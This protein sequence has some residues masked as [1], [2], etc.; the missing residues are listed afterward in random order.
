[1]HRKRFFGLRS[2]ILMFSLIITLLPLLLV[3]TFS[4]RES[5]QMVRSQV[6]DLNLVNAEQI[7]NNL[8]F[9]MNDVETI[10]LNLIQNNVLNDYLLLSNTENRH[11]REPE[12]LSLLNDQLFNKRY[13]YSIYIEDAYG[14]GLDVRGAGNTVDGER[15]LQLQQLRGKEMWYFNSIAIGARQVNAISMVREIRDVNNLSRPL[16]FMKIN[17][18]ES[19]IRDLYRTQVQ[20]KGQFYLLDRDGT[21]LS[22]ISGKEAGTRLDTA[23][24]Y[25]NMAGA[26]AGHFNTTI[27]GERYLA[28][29][30]RMQPIG[31]QIVQLIP[32]DY[33]SQSGDVIGRVTAI[34]IAASL[35]ICIGFILLFAARVLKPLK[36]IRILMKQVEN[37]NF[38][39]RM[40]E[41]GNDEM[42]LLARSFNRMSNKLDELV[43]EVH[44]SKIKQ[45]EAELKAL[46]EQINPHFLYNTL[47]LIYW[48]SR[49]EKAFETSVMIN[50][51]SQLFRI[52]LNS[53]SG[54]TTV[55][56]EV[57]HLHY[58]MLIQQ[59]RY[60][61]EILFTI[62]MEEEAMDCKVTKIILQPL[63][64]NAIS[65]GIEQKGGSGSIRIRI[66]R[67]GGDLVYT[68]TDNG[69]GADEA[70]VNA[71]LHQ[72]GED[73][74]GLALKN[75]NDRIQL[76]FGGSYGIDFHSV[77]MEGTTVTVRQ[78][79]L[80]GTNAH[81]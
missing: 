51:L 26:A 18:L 72:T 58:Y 42:T 49:M 14:N 1:M 12:I 41:R 69:A 25:P 53:G 75:I 23:S 67:E 60:E 81:V 52:G 44:V 19:D 77:P 16:G 57:D 34:T 27:E 36:Q 55:S 13:I 21:I 24:H 22:T 74:R 46:E 59:K 33:I 2:K 37:E 68:V 40:E 76:N 8:T 80:K 6:I 31:W 5:I 45:K 71:L 65:H 64:E 73:N 3:S 38:N 29:F 30:D 63:V 61:E 20:D 47:D 4:Y 50:A 28:I 48:M 10:S 79:W 9:I 78:P 35:V 15:T 62:D 70:A 11:Q 32:Y 43:N 66:F 17:I 39:M 54:F 7:A 56:R